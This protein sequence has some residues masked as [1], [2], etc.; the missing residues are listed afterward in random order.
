MNVIHHMD[1]LELVDTLPDA[2]IDMAMLDLPYGT[3]SCAWD[4]I[5]PFAP[6]WTGLKRVCKRGA[7]MVFTASQ[8]FTSALVMSN[9]GMFRY[10]WMWDKVQPNGFLQS[11]FMP[12]KQHESILVFS[13]SAITYNPQMTAREKPR[14][15]KARDYS[16][17]K[18]VYRNYHAVGGEYTEY[19]PRS[20]LKFSS[21]SNNDTLHP[22]QKPVAL[23]EYLI[24]T[25]TQPGDVVLDFVCGSGTTAV[26]AQN[27]GRKFICGDS[28]LPYVEIARHRLE[29]STL[30]LPFFEAI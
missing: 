19:Y 21:G 30:P 28:H 17:N 8:P 2:S 7:A 3:T 9:V 22:T 16:T 20:I 6:M 11:K 24:R 29:T 15:D 4:E 12:L 1:A 25:Y 5:I 26:A 10:E 18:T 23:F 13:A 14:V 27:T